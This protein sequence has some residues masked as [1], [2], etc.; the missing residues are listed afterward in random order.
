VKTKIKKEYLKEEARHHKAEEREESKH[1]K[2]ESKDLDKA[3]KLG[4]EKKKKH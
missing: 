3:L 4:K 2:R 1:E